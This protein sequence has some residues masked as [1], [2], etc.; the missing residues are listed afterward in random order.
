VS[1]LEN[2]DEC[3]RLTVDPWRLDI[4]YDDGVTSGAL[5][6]WLC[7]RCAWSVARCGVV[8]LTVG[9]AT[10]E[11]LREPSRS[12]T[13]PRGRSAAARDGRTPRVSRGPSPAR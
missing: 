5:F 2:C 1:D 6:E 13:G 7:A 3:G 8:D 4:A 9:T 10:V 12:A 11:A